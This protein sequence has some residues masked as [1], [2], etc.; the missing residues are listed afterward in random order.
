MALVI[1][2]RG[3]LVLMAKNV[4]RLSDGM[5]RYQ[6]RI[7][8]DLKA[9]YP[10]AGAFIRKNIGKDPV[11]AAREGARLTAEHDALWKQLRSPQGDAH[12]VTTSEVRAGAK[13]LLGMLDFAPGD[14]L[15]EWT[16]DPPI[17]DYLHRKYGEEYARARHESQDPTADV[18]ELVSP[19]EREAIR[20]L[21][22]DPAKPRK[23]LSEITEE[24]LR[25]HR[26]G[27]KRR[28]IKLVNLAIGVVFEAAGD[29]P[30]Q[31]YTRQHAIAVRDRL[32]SRRNKTTTV[33]RRL[34]TIDAIVNHG[35]REYGLGIRSPFAQLSIPKEGADPVDREPFTHSELQAIARAARAKDDDLRHLVAM[36]LDTGARLAEIVGL[37]AADLRLD[38]QVP[39]ILIRE[40]LAKGRTLKNAYS[41]RR[42]PLVG[43]ALWA[44]GR[45]R[46]GMNA[47]Q[48][49]VFPRYAAENNIR[50]DSA[51]GTL[52]KWL[53]GVTG[54]Q[55]TAHSFRH[56][57]RDRLREARVPKEFQD[58][59][60]GWEAP[61]VGQSYGEGYSLDILR[62]HMVKVLLEDP[63]MKPLDTLDS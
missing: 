33:R 2:A 26:S 17:Q 63:R 39:H 7:P 8:K 52:A 57:M 40:D 42:V 19:V 15:Q 10:N 1:W 38:A 46:E 56:S 37:Q 3:A 32:L 36:L 28:F 18:A 62:E 48:G 58:L 13:A 20:L 9:H 27:E 34:Q 21:Y 51:S 29:V 35:I 54:M 53:R 6:R 55:K 43:E 50:A 5:Y 22:E 59:L 11:K 24:Y 30:L 25:S 61:T 41:A 16:D 47:T 31:M 12:D 49:W 44:A 4:I 14:G 60:G 45:L 23:L